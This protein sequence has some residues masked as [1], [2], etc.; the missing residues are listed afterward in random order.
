VRVEDSLI[1]GTSKEFFDPFI[2]SP[3]EEIIK[4]IENV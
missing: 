4:A 2:H 1:I 3:Y